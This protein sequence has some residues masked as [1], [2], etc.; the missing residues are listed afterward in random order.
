MEFRCPYH[1]W[2][3]DATTGRLRRATGIK[4]IENF[5]ARASG[6]KPLRV[7]V[8]GREELG[9]G[10]VFVAERTGGGA[11]SLRDELGALLEAYAGFFPPRSAD[12]RFVRRRAYDLASN[13][14]VFVDNYLDGGY[15][16]PHA[17]P[18][19]DAA[20]DMDA[21]RRESFDRGHSI[22]TV[23]SSAASDARLGD[24][25]ACYAYAFPTFMLNRYGPWCDTNT[26]VPLAPDRCR[27]VFDYYLEEDY[28]TRELGGDET[29]VAAFVDESLAASDGVQLEDEDLCAGVQAGLASRGYDQGR[30]NPNFE[31]PMYAFHARLSDDYRR[32]LGL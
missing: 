15:H 6:L 29:R 7:E 20:I 14:K 18:A 12:L 28:V 26:V 17:H 22:Q 2:R 23:A 25:G 31:G 32:A 27:V 5:S 13:W 3:Y 4:G 9:V 8:L 24:R 30:Y 21:Y 19:L 16:V 10:L 1:G 11:G